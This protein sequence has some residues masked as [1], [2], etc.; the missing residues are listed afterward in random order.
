MVGG[1]AGAG[2][3][4]NV[5]GLCSR[6]GVAAAG[7][8]D[9]VCGLQRLAEKLAGR[10]SVGRA[11]ELLEE[12][13][14]RGSRAGFADGP[15]ASSDT[16]SKWDDDAG[17]IA[18]GV[19]PE[20]EG[21]DETGRGDAVHDAAGG[22][23]GATASLQRAERYSS[24]FADRRTDTAGDGEPDRV[25]REHVGIAGADREREDIF[26][27]VAGGEGDDAGSVCAPGCAV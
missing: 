2:S 26:G 25:F 1:S 27:V 21:A 12:A 9:S 18:C 24:W 14:G 6:E 7:M 20:G 11:D 22:I 8:A 13:V 15:E 19:E 4:G 23:S 17:G 5:P 10:R 16:D 3:I